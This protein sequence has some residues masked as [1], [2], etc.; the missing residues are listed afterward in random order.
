MH[1]RGYILWRFAKPEPGIY[2][3]R[4]TRWQLMWDRVNGVTTEP[5][6]ITTFSHITRCGTWT[7]RWGRGR[8]PCPQCDDVRLLNTPIRRLNFQ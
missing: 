6:R 7:R 3:V 1:E 8:S 5:V 2:E 4:P